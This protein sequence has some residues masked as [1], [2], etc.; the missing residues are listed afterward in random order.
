[1][2]NEN[3]IDFEASVELRG[4]ED[5]DSRIV[6]RRGAHSHRWRAA[7]FAYIGTRQLGSI[8]DGFLRLLV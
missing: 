3:F 5:C 6:D 2:R 4:C 8:A 1:V 7:S